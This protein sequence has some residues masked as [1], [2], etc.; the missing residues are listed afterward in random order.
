MKRTFLLSHP[1]QFTVGRPDVLI[2][3]QQVAPV[4]VQVGHLDAVRTEQEALGGDTWGDDAVR[5]AAVAGLAEQYPGDEIE[6]VD[7]V[8]W[9]QRTTDAAARAATAS[10]TQAVS[11]GTPAR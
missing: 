8:E 9:E 7:V 4:R 3:V 1:V 6:V 2:P 10:E 5:A 11:P